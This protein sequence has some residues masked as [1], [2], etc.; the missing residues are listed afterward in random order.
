MK[1]NEN[2]ITGIYIDVIKITVAWKLKQEARMFDWFIEVILWMMVLWR[3]V[4]TICVY[5]IRESFQKRGGYYTW[6]HW[7]QVKLISHNDENHALSMTFSNS[8]LWAWQ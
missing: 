7:Y 2:L 5:E 1:E 3:P 8:D 4:R 6:K